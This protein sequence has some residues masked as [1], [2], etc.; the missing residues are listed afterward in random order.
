MKT[1][2]ISL[3]LFACAM[4]LC[5]TTSC[6]DDFVD[7]NVLGSISG[8]VIDVD[9]H[10]PVQSAI[11]TLSPSGLNTYTGLDGY[12]EFLDPNVRQYTVTVQKTGYVTN[13]KTVT[14]NAGGNVNI[15]LTLQKNQ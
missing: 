12:F 5:I 15:S 3:L 9:T 2:R 7:Y 11:V 1:K 8:T 10:D 13:R 14:T 4:L 6:D